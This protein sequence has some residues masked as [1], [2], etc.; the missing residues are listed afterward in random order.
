M[1]S[2][3]SIATENNLPVVM[4]GGGEITEKGFELVLSKTLFILKRKQGDHLNVLITVAFEYMV[5]VMDMW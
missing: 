1:S 5:P 2:R 4:A 3:H